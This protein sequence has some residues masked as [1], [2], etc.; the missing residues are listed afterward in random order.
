MAAGRARSLSDGGDPTL[1]QEDAKRSNREH[2]YL[3]GER[4]R[5]INRLKAALARL[6]YAI[7]TRNYARRPSVCELW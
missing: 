5:V 4:T 6:E 1:E 7:S 3:V 2:Q